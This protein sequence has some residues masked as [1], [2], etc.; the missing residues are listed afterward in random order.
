MRPLPPPAHD[1]GAARG[2]LALCDVPVPGLR[3]AYVVTFCPPEL[4]EWA[5]REG[6]IVKPK[7]NRN[8]KLI[9]GRWYFDFTLGRKRYIRLGG[10][11][12]PEAVLAMARLRD[13]LA[14]VSQ[15]APAEVEDPLFA[16][17]PRNTSSFTRSRTSGPGNGTSA[18]SSTWTGPSASF[19]F[20]DHAP[21][22]RAI[23]RR[24]SRVSP[25]HRQSRARVPQGHPEQGA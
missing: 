13:E 19:P 18:R 24:P 14:K 21:R 20:E 11:T 12:K 10:R 2:R 16:T 22:R 9:E 7:H 1:R 8:L 4:A 17:S 25:W 3:S 15:L 6:S 23:P 5:R